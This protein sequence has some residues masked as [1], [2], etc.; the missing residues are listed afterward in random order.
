MKQEKKKNPKLIIIIA[1][2]V[3]A[4]IIGIIALASGNKENQQAKIMTKEE[5]L[6]QNSIFLDLPSLDSELN[7]NLAR[8]KEKYKTGTIYKFEGF[9]NSIYDSYIE[10]HS[11]N[12]ILY[13]Y[14]PVEEIKLLDKQQ[15]IG[16]V[17]KLSNIDIKEQEKMSYGYSYTEKNT[18]VTF[19]NS[20]I[21]QDTFEITGTVNIPKPASIFT[22]PISD[23]YCNIDVG[24]T[25]KVRYDITEYAKEKSFTNPSIV[26]GITL[27]NGNNV[28]I[29]GKVFLYGETNS[30]GNKMNYI[31]KDLKS[32]KVNE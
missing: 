18:I 2:V 13:V 5:M 16:I 7:E 3:V 11:G 26:N 10:L 8:T 15:K 4:V 24:T 32:I 23:W 28:T 6:K 21:M 31:I 14:L 29:T 30:V 20:Y 9:V 22:P 27:E 19:D 25:S 17:G 12:L 1:I